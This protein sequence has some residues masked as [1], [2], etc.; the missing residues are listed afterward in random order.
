MAAKVF[1][2]L[3]IYGGVFPAFFVSV[4][5]LIKSGELHGE[6]HPVIGDSLVSRARNRI[7][8]DFLKSDCTHLLFLDCD[9]QFNPKQVKQL[10]GHGEHC[11]IVCALYPKKQ[12]ELAWVMNIFTGVQ[13]PDQNG[14]L[15]VK[16]A[17]TGA[18]LIRRDVIQKMQEAYPSLRYDEDAGGAGSKYDLFKVGTWPC[19]EIPRLEF[20]QKPVDSQFD[21]PK[22]IPAQLVKMR[23]ESRYLSEDWFFCYLAWNLG[24][25]TFID[26]RNV[27]RHWDGCTS[28]PVG[29]IPTENLPAPAAPSEV[30]TG[31]QRVA[32]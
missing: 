7:V 13:T 17:G 32:A 28:Y 18:M 24:I 5:N 31:G 11:P 3:P 4:V 29:P 9:L 14:L 1:I 22:E 8:A 20:P 10:L 16:C 19:A 23:D 12:V 30:Q 26:T 25:P 15:P 27:F 2:G 21:L 6:I